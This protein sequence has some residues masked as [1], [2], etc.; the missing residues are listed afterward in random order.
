MLC[1]VKGARIESLNDV[2]LMV[3]KLDPLSYRF[4]RK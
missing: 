1:Y 2:Q 4:I 3:R